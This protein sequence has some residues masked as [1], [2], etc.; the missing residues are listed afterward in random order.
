MSADPPDGD[1]R[2]LQQ[3]RALPEVSEAITRYG[4]LADLFRDLAPRLR[5]VV[6]F[7]C[8]FLL[9]HDPAENAMRLHILESGRPEA[10]SLP[11]GPTPLESPSGLVWQTQEPMVIPD[12]EQETCFPHMTPI[13]RSRCIRSGGY[14]PLTVAGRRIGTINFASTRPGGYDAADLQ[15]LHQVA[16]VVAVAVDNALNFQSARCYQ[17]QLPGERERLRLLLDINNAVVAHLDLRD[18][19]RGIADNLGR[20][21]QQDY[22]SLALYAAADG[23][24]LYAID[25]PSGKGLLREEIVVPFAGAPASQAFTSRQTAVYGPVE[26]ERLGSGVARL[27]PAEDVRSLC[28][29][30]L[31]SHDRTL[32]TLNVGRLHDAGFTPAEVELLGQVGTQIALAVDNALAFREIAALKDKLAEE[33]LYLEE[34][35][36]TGHNFSEIVGASPAIQRVLRQVEIVAPSDTAVLIQGETGTGKELV[37]RAIHNLSKRRDRTF[38]KINCAA[39]PT[40]L[41]ES[42]LCGHEKGAFTGAI[43]RKVGRFELA[44][45]GT[46]FLDEAGDIPLTLQPKLLRVLQEQ[47]FERLGSTQ[48]QRVDVRLVAATNRDLVQMVADRQFRSDL[49]YRLNVFP[50]TLPPLRERQEDIP[51]LVRHFVRQHARKLNRPIRS[52]PAEALAAL[53]RYPWPGNVRELADFVERAELLSPGSEL[54]LSLADLKTSAAPVGPPA[55]LADAEREHILDVLRQTNWVLGG[56]SGAAARLGLKRTTLQSKMQKLGIR[57]PHRGA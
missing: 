20:V 21:I 7:D 56:P 2:C 26:L 32:G 28:C 10:V 33:K 37:A 52:V 27:L 40:G 14:V 3:Y 47:E 31:A 53:T 39:I 12:Y 13:W 50:L 6:P 42:E 22:T 55:T 36:R 11:H 17:R 5:R 18:L 45:G 8:L 23:W 57:R 25:F 30:P 46:L 35:I 34:E 24:H 48:T 19:F 4:D 54:R 15:F 51:L 1:A 43:A 9:L 41:L 49:Y 44:H 16:R 29:V 38:V